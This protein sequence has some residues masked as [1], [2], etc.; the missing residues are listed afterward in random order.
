MFTGVS[1]KH[2]TSIFR[3]EDASSDKPILIVTA[4]RTYNLT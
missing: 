4:Q 1:E 3:V 2:A